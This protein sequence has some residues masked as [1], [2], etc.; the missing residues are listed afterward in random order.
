M[1]SERVIG[2]PV[3]AAPPIGRQTMP[4]GCQTIMPL[5][6]RPPSASPTHDRLASYGELVWEEPGAAVFERQS[7]NECALRLRAIY[8]AA[9]EHDTIAEDDCSPGR[10]PRRSTAADHFAICPNHA[11]IHVEDGSPRIAPEVLPC[12]HFGPIVPCSSVAAGHDL[13]KGRLATLIVCP[14]R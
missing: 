4:I 2:G 6:Q 12:P 10:L 14:E 5:G 9:R 11:T 8:S 1:P 3:E 7:I 13:E